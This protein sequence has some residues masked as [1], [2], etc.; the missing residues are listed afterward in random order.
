MDKMENHVQEML[1]IG[2]HPAQSR[3]SLR[4]ASA[5]D[6]AALKAYIIREIH[7]RVEAKLSTIVDTALTARMNRLEANHKTEQMNI[8]TLQATRSLDRQVLDDL[9]AF[10]RYEHSL[11]SALVERLFQASSLE[12][13][14]EARFVETTFDLQGT[15]SVNSVLVSYV[16]A[17]F[18]KVR[19]L[20][21]QVSGLQEIFV[22]TAARS[23]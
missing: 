14:P 15:D 18:M 1:D 22:V 8:K 12:G 11:N 16:E 3:R 7:A 5:P 9:D 23:K 19:Q 13:D 4:T 6:N 20:E 2:H 21:E 10:H 17:L